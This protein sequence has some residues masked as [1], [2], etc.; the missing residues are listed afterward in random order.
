[1]TINWSLGKSRSMFFKLWVRAPR[2]RIVSIASHTQKMG[3]II[4]ITHAISTG[5]CGGL[6][7]RGGTQTLQRCFAVKCEREQRFPLYMS[8]WGIPKGEIAVLPPFWCKQ[9][10]G[11]CA[12]WKQGSLPA[13]FSG[14]GW[15]ERLLYCGRASAI[16][17]TL[18][19]QTNLN[20]NR[21]RRSLPR[22]TLILI[23]S[24]RHA[25]IQNDLH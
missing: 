20:N 3:Y 9:K 21:S 23:K 13:F 22:H 25:N 11:F 15:N 24:S 10:R 4:S 16:I 8:R 18:Q 1:M 19:D 6:A 5:A 14:N 17:V 12:A 7:K 2:I